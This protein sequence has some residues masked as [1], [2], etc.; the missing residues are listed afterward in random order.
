MLTPYFSSSSEMTNHVGN[1]LDTKIYSNSMQR[2]FYGISNDYQFYTVSNTNAIYRKNIITNVEADEIT[3]AFDIDDSLWE[4]IP[5]SD[6]YGFIVVEQ[7]D[8]ISG[9]PTGNIFIYDIDW[10]SLSSILRET[11]TYTYQYDDENE[12]YFYFSEVL[13]ATK[14]GNN[15][16]AILQMYNTTRTN[17]NIDF[18]FLIYDY[19]SNSFS[20]L[21]AP[22]NENDKISI[23][24]SSNFTSIADLGSGISAFIIA[25]NA[26]LISSS[27]LGNT[28]IAIV[29]TNNKSVNYVALP[30]NISSPLSD[31]NY[32]NTILSLAPYF[33]NNSVYVLTHYQVRIDSQFISY[34]KI[35]N[36]DSSGN[37]SEIYVTDWIDPMSTTDNRILYS[38]NNIISCRY[39]GGYYHFYDLLTSG[40]LFT[41]PYFSNTLMSSTM[42][43]VDESIVLLQYREASVASTQYVNSEMTGWQPDNNAILYQNGW[44]WDGWDNEAPSLSYQENYIYGYYLDYKNDTP[45]ALSA[46]GIV[47][48]ASTNQFPPDSYIASDLFYSKTFDCTTSSYVII[49]LE[50]GK[51]YMITSAGTY[52][53]DNG[54]H[55]F[56]PPHDPSYST[57]FLAPNSVSCYGKIGQDLDIVDFSYGN[58]Y[59]T[60]EAPYARPSA[61]NKHLELFIYASPTYTDRHDPII[62]VSFYDYKNVGDNEGSLDVKIYEAIQRDKLEICASVN[63]NGVASKGRHIRPIVKF[64]TLWGT[65]YSHHTTVGASMFMRVYFTDGSYTEY[66]GESAGYELDDD[67]IILESDDGKIFSKIV[68]G[69]YFGDIPP[70]DNNGYPNLDG[71]LY[72]LKIVITSLI[73]ETV[74]PAYYSLKK[75]LPNGNI[76]EILDVD[77]IVGIPTFLTSLRY[78]RLVGNYV[79]IPYSYYSNSQFLICYTGEEFNLFKKQFRVIWWNGG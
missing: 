36:I 15:I 39:I 5:I 28:Y 58:T 8:D 33:V 18:N 66:G 49:H 72:S 38:K 65:E 24:T 76:D 46:T 71:D 34:F 16:C 78:V 11:Y 50:Y 67:Y 44:N 4:Y 21:D 75:V 41:V 63:I 26:S 2:F 12:I 23:K 68:F 35:L 48:N 53:Y 70:C 43:D 7:Y 32:A 73:V 52:M 64:V 27:Y 19:Q 20:L 14:N 54:E 45:T 10:I 74:I 37:I 1:V 13:G 6:D 59:Q 47:L 60:G 77:A 62:F 22:D 25:A 40:S 79:I 9:D 3:N 29:N 61:D 55:A 31:G 57:A 30:R 42:D 69:A 17:P 56:P 51:R